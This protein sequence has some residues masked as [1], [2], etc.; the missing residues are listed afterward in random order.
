MSAHL[1]RHHHSDTHVTLQEELI[2]LQSDRPSQYDF[3]RGGIAE[4]ALIGVVKDD[5]HEGVDGGAAGSLV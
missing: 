4:K 2:L 5:L 3:V 1:P